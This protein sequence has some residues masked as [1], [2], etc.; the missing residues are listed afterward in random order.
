MMRLLVAVSEAEDRNEDYDIT[1]D[2][3]KEIAGYRKVVRITD[4]K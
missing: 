1:I 3:G 2:D 4:E